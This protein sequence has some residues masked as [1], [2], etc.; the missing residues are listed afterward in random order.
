MPRTSTGAPPFGR[1]SRWNTF[2]SQSRPSRWSITTRR[3]RPRRIVVHVPRDLLYL[4]P[5]AFGRGC[6][7]SARF[8]FRRRHRWQLGDLVIRDDRVVQHVAPRDYEWRSA[9]SCTG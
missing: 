9:A 3:P 7:A 2:S 6:F 1:R 4:L 8:G 5:K